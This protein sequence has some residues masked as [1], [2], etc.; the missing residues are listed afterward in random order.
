MALLI[1]LLGLPFTITFCK[2]EKVNNT[3]LTCCRNS[4]TYTH[5][6]VKCV[7]YGVFIHKIHVK[8]TCETCIECKYLHELYEHL[9]YTQ[10][11]SN[12]DEPRIFCYS[13]TQTPCIFPREEY[14]N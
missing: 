4:S 8:Y 2:F 1:L 3:V 12:S 10:I 14:T 6:H 7:Q 13:Y 11:E 9:N 5:V